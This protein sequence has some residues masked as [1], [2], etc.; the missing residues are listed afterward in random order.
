MSKPLPRPVL[1]AS[2]KSWATASM[3]SPMHCAAMA[4]CNGCTSGTRRSPPLA[5][6]RRDRTTRGAMER[7]ERATQAEMP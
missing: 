6:E 2:M 4:A 1:S 5:A 7:L 3:A